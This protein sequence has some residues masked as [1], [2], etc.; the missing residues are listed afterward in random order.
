MTTQPT[1]DELFTLIVQSGLL[2][3]DQLAPYRVRSGGEAVTA[4]T[5]ARNLVKDR[6]LTVF[7]ARLLLRGKFRGFFLT[8]KFKVLE[9]LGE[10]GM[11]KVLLCEHLILHKLVAVKLLHAPTA[12][13]SPGAIQRF[14][15]EAR[16][17]AAVEHPNIV[18]VTDVE[19]GPTPFMV[20]EYVDGTNLHQL[21]TN[22]GPLAINRA[23]EYIRQAAVGLHAAHMAGLIHRD[24]KP[25]NLLLA[26]S[27]LVKLVDL[28]LA[29]FV[30]NTGE[31]QNLTARFDDNAILGTADFI[32]PEQTMD[33]SSVDIRADI[34]SLGHTFYFLLSGRMP[35]GDGTAAQKLVWHQLKQPEPISMIRREI[36]KT[37]QLVLDKMIEK[38]PADRYQTPAEVVEAL[39]PLLTGPVPPPPANEM[40][41]VRP[42][43][44]LLGLSPPPPAYLLA[45]TNQANANT[46]NLSGGDTPATLWS[47]RPSTAGMPALQPGSGDYSTPRPPQ[48]GSGDLTGSRPHA[49]HGPSSASMTSRRRSPQTVPMTTPLTPMDEDVPEPSP[50]G[51]PPAPAKK[52]WIV[53]GSLMGA[54]VVLLGAVLYLA[55]VFDKKLVDNSPFVRPTHP[56]SGRPTDPGTVPTPPEKGGGPDK[57]PPRLILRGAGS[58]FVAPMMSKWSEEYEKE[59]RVRIEYDKRGSSKGVA[60][61]LEKNFDFGGT[62]ATVTEEQLSKVKASYKDILHIPLVMG[63]VVPT[64]NVPDVPQLKFTGGVLVDIYSGK[65]THWDDPAI[66]AS[67]N[68]QLP[69]L[70]IT[71]VRRSDGSGTTNIWT[72][73]LC[74]LDQGFSQKIGGPSNL[75][76][77]PLVDGKEI[78]V[79]GEGNDGVAAQVRKIPGAI[80]YVELNFALARSL[81]Y[82][83]VENSASKFINPTL[84]RVTA[85]AVSKL[86]TIP[87]DLRYTLTNAPG[88]G[89]YPIC[90]T[91]W[92]VI[93]V[94]Q[95][96]EKAKDLV[97]FLRWC[98]H[99][100]QKYTRDLNYAPL[101]QELV[102]RIDRLL[103][104]VPGA[105]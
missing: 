87:D 82:G 6:L 28:G 41:K 95:P 85:A 76:K 29:R 33:S 98:V 92:A 86:D 72:S 77:W 10:G 105:N 53:L 104:R 60:A 56:G 62:D 65:I 25:G 55:G 22:H 31:N 12:D 61:V 44:Y 75:P 37:V 79:A 9:L 18:R 1:T 68:V 71:P 48:P 50:Y 57:L 80:G 2:A 30:Q 78:G 102:T 23:V 16:A 99:D 52:P 45:L 8:E 96:P 74:E 51:A 101:P 11:G 66:K 38:R 24:I 89:S 42:S 21:I 46:P 64:Y 91:T 81:A 100:G 15:R 67:N 17:S 58:T 7:Q 26:R 63:A 14:I 54:V 70:P 97:K 103:D 34:Y 59:F 43:S 90:G 36:P 20:M 83:Q 73:Y 32:A 27:G 35:F 5:V 19:A 49:P 94:D 39:R 69:H 13:S 88:Q 47:V 40:P 3:A 4:E 93:Y 84:D